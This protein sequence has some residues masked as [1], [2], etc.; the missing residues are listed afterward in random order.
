M[1]EGR[2]AVKLT[3]SQSTDGN[4]RGDIP[5]GTVLVLLSLNDS[6]RRLIQAPPSKR[7]AKTKAHSLRSS[8]IVIR[9]LIRSFHH[10]HAGACHAR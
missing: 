9:L 2:E 3:G 10:N 1:E 7:K 4:K 6:I 5:K 8:L